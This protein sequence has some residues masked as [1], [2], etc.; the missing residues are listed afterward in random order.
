MFDMFK[1]DV[2]F[3]DIPHNVVNAF[4]NCFDIFQA[5]VSLLFNITRH[6]FT[7]FCVH[8]QLS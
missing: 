3:D 2:Y 4:D 8:R 5:L 6:H 7:R 1:D